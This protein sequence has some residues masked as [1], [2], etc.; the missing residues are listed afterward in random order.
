MSGNVQE[1]MLKNKLQSCYYTFLRLRTFFIHRWQL[2]TG[3]EE[4]NVSFFL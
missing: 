4:K 2:L 3:V 1:D